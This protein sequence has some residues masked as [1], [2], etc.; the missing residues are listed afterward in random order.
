MSLKNS[1]FRLLPFLCITSLSRAAAQDAPSPKGE[2]QT[3]GKEPLAVLSDTRAEL[4]LNGIWQF[5]PMRDKAET[6]PSEG[7]ANIHVPG[8]W[9]ENGA[10]PGL[11]SGPGKGP[12]W[13]NWGN[14]S[15]VWC[16]W[17]QRKVSI[18][19]QWEGRA[20][21]LSLER[22]STD[23]RVYANGQHCGAIGW[24]YGE[25]D[26]SKAV[27]AGGEAVLRIQVMATKDDT[28]V[29][30]FL[31][32]GRGVTT[33]ANLSSK[34]LIGDVF[35]RCRPL[36]T[37]VRDVFVQSSTR[38]Q[39]LK[40]AVE[41]C[42]V[43]AAE[44]LQI[45]AKL[46]GMSG[47]EE[48]SFQG[49]AVVKEGKAQILELAWKWTNPKLWDLQQPNLY[50]LKLKC[51]G[52]KWNDEYAQPFGFREFWID[53]RKF[54]LN[55]TEIRL[56]PI[57]HTYMETRFG[58]FVELTDDHIEGCL[59]A[60]FNIEECWPVNH[61]EKGSAYFREL[62]ADRAD[63]KGFL[64]MGTAL[65]INEGKWDKADYR[66]S[67][68]R[69]LDLDLRRYRNHPSIVLWTT[70][71]NW[72]GNGL[73][74]DPWHI[75]RSQ[76][77]PGALED[78]KKKKAAEAVAM[79]K[80]VDP[81]RPVF[82]HAGA[83]NGDL[84]NINCYLNFMPLQEREELLSEWAKSGDMPLLCCEFGTP[85]L[86]SFLRGRWGFEGSTEPLMTEYCA[87]YLGNEAYSL[88]TAGYR[89]AIRKKYGGGLRFGD[90]INGETVIEASPA[91][92]KVEALFNLNTYRSWRT[93][94]ITGGMVPWDYGY[95]WDAFN[96]ERRRTNRPVADQALRPFTP[97]ARGLARDRE[98]ISLF[99]PFQPEGMDT[100]PAGTALME[101]NG[102]TL[103]WIAGS[104]ESFTSKDHSFIAAQDVMKQVVLINDERGAKDYSYS[105]S[106][107]LGGKSFAA[108]SGKGRIE[109][110]KTLFLPLHV[111]L[112]EL[113]GPTKAA[114]TIS[115]LA[116]IGT[117]E[118]KDVFPFHVFSKGAPLQQTVALV[119][120]V[121][122]TGKMLEALGCKVQKWD[123]KTLSELIVVGREALSGGG[124]PPLDGEAIVRA[125]GRILVCSQDPAWLREKMGFRVAAQLTRRVFPV[126]ARHPACQDL[127]GADLSD[128][129][130]ESTLVEAYPK[131][132]VQDPRWRSPKYGFH[133][134]NRGVVT[135]AAIEKP[136]RSGWR[137][138]LECEFDLAYSPL[139]ELEYGEG[140]LI[141]CTLDL[142]D[143]V[144]VDPA[145]ALLAKNILRYLASPRTTPRAKRTILVGDPQDQQTLKDLGLVFQAAADIDA[146]A[147]LAIIGRQAQCNEPKMQDYLTRGGRALFLPRTGSGQEFGL[148][149][150]EEPS[151]A[152]SL[153]IPAWPECQGL[154]SSDLRWRTECPAWLV[155]AGVETGANGLLGVLRKGSGVALFCQID[156]DR[157]QVDQKPYLR[158]TRWR[159]TRALAQILANLGASF[160]VDQN[161]V[162]LTRPQAGWY[163]P[164]YHADDL[165]NSDDP[166]LYFRW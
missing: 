19:S 160:E 59:R 47:Q 28:P 43:P 63:L 13:Q 142:E 90:W 33:A 35:L 145:A 157:F 137:P 20:I 98:A 154:S 36:G 9:K 134:G 64:L 113:A 6:E 146:D 25:V 68:R 105:W 139:L 122:K 101:A 112:P 80:Q 27:K 116:K 60:G 141:L 143:H 46:I 104:K 30:S 56:R 54:L 92:Q 26:I 89:Q 7:M 10:L 51:Q 163:H 88:E 95:A 130:G 126:S 138:I 69:K 118:Q 144:L 165:K 16:A 135:S 97:G 110:A 72:L 117:R 166:Y 23:A 40:L 65:P 12:A 24:P 52:A 155:D 129:S 78:W 91:F 158:I 70:N 120:P 96:S 84:F 133:W 161:A 75:G 107:E 87:I 29:T 152:G 32:P 41:L 147:G 100:Y 83:N 1:A 114:G 61:D 4:C 121:G 93:W 125:G 37:H 3:S 131:L 136:H 86:L 132:P 22:V 2:H 74:Q 21:L 38:K 39:E 57:C 45:T 8:S 44:T 123:G 162:S 77:I 66:E 48:K 62:W 140:R 150:K 149:L 151:S 111:R 15:G 50:T 148:K 58:G 76:E 102:P 81:T 109:P 79:I 49:S 11:V 106:A 42:D 124:P 99:K 85:W 17:Y 127:D 31:D 153:I 119:D 156:P 164:D 108:D 71:P 53:G 128:W 55:G 73:D 5:V 82:N 18:P 34:G 159:E 14:G 67:Y 94:G 103:A 115:L